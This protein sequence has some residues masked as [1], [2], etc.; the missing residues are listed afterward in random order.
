[1][2]GSNSKETNKMDSVNNTN[3]KLCQNQQFSSSTGQINTNKIEDGCIN[4]SEVTTNKSI[5]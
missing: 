4:L 3:Q 1:M 2:G 5:N